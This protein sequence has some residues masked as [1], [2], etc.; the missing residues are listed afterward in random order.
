MCHIPN[1][2]RDTAVSLYSS[3]IVDKKETTMS[4]CLSIYLWLYSPFVG[5]WSLFQFLNPTHSR[6]DFLDGGSTR[7]KAAT[8]THNNTNTE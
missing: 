5:P 4:V 7:R 8:Y 1:G 2:F 3:K 6:Q